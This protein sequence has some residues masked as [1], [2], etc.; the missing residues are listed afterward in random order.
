MML[1]MVLIWVDADIYADCVELAGAN[2]FFLYKRK[3]N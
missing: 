2:C 3:G 1:Q